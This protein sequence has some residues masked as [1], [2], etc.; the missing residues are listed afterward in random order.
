MIIYYMLKI[1]FQII[2]QN[3][4]K[5]DLMYIKYVIETIR[6]IEDRC[7]RNINNKSD[8]EGRVSGIIGSCVKTYLTINYYD[9]LANIVSNIRNQIYGYSLL[10]DSIITNSGFT[11][12]TLIKIEYCYV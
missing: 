4:T 9:N 2:Y 6:N 3:I 7:L 1:Y 8:N 12:T 11:A 5:D 10:F